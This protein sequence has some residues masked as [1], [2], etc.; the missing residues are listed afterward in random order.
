MDNL[1]KSPSQKPDYSFGILDPSDQKLFKSLFQ[2]VDPSVLEKYTETLPRFLQLLSQNGTSREEQRDFIFEMT[3]LNKLHWRGE[4][5]DNI[6]DNIYTIYQTLQ[7]ENIPIND[8]SRQIIFDTTKVD[9]AWLSY[10]DTDYLDRLTRVLKQLSNLHRT[11]DLQ[12]FTSILETLQFEDDGIVIHPKTSQV[13]IFDKTDDTANIVSTIAVHNIENQC[14]CIQT[15]NLIFVDQKFTKAISE[16]TGKKVIPNLISMNQFP[17]S[18]FYSRL[19]YYTQNTLGLMQTMN[20]NNAVVLDCGC[21]SGVLSLAAAKQGAKVI[22]IDYNEKLIN[23]A[24]K[25]AIT[26]GY[27]LNENLTF[28]N[29]DLRDTDKVSEAVLRVSQG[30]P[31]IIISNIGHW[32]KD[33]PISSLTSFSYIPILNRLGISVPYVIAGG[34]DGV[35]DV[36]IYKSDMNFLNNLDINKKILS[37]EPM[38]CDKTVMQKMGYDRTK[39]AISEYFLLPLNFFSRNAKSCMYTYSK[40]K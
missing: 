1:E 22:G 30:K 16:S 24:Q 21:G 34:Y 15:G 29:A 40:Q 20:F 32:P 28:V 4:F 13:T 33:Y 26:N 3:Q 31:V 38:V 2:N 12:D 36:K 19:G 23:M 5:Y 6:F 10:H 25:N 17:K 35:T 18:E 7:A 37:K 27:K 11:P 8:L 39:I 9:Q 14:V